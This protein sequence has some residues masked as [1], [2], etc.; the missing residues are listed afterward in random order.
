MKRILL[1]FLAAGVVLAGVGMASAGVLSVEASPTSFSA[2]GQEIVISYRFGGENAPVFDVSFASTLGV[3]VVC[4][5]GGGLD[6][7]DWTTCQGTYVTTAADIAAGAIQESG[8]YLASTMSGNRPGGF[9]PVAVALADV[10]EPPAPVAC[11][12]PEGGSRFIFR[13]RRTGVLPCN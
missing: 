6:I 8:S 2:P 10:P 9:G 13:S 5:L 4:D 7:G 3:D 11:H 1:P 12:G